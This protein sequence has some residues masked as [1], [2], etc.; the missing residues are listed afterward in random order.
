MIKK[1]NIYFKKVYF[2]GKRSKLWISTN[3][4]SDLRKPIG[5]DEHLYA[6]NFLILNFSV[7]I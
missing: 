2:K 6:T 5:H 3:K 4:L 1:Q 7:L